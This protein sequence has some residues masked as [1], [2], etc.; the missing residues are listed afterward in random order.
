MIP[1]EASCCARGAGRESRA[2]GVDLLR[3]ELTSASCARWRCQLPAPHLEQKTGSEA[4]LAHLGGSWEGG[5][6]EANKGAL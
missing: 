1:P 2:A 3:A 5:G 4:K 6:G